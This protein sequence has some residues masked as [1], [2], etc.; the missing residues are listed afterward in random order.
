MVDKRYYWRAKLGKDRPFI[1]VMT[2]FAG[3]W[4]DGEEQ[5]RSPRWQ[6]LVRL[7]TSGRAILM[8]DEVPIE[9]DGVSLRNIEKI[10]EADYRYMVAHADYATKHA[11]HLPDASPKQAISWNRT[12]PVF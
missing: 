7:E 9:V 10:S 3:P 5:D 12:K 1:P 6:A 8:G 4:V 11:P 2:F